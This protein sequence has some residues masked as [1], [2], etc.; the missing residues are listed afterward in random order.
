M[1]PRAVVVDHMTKTEAVFA[2]YTDAAAQ[3]AYLLNLGHDVEIKKEGGNES[4]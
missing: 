3:A 4:R 2:D 1:K